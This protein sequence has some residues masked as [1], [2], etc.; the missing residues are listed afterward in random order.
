M[1]DVTQPKYVRMF[2]PTNFYIPGPWRILTVHDSVIY[3][4]RTIVP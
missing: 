1:Y 2:C 3:G 4:T